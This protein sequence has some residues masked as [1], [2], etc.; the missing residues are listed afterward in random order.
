MTPPPIPVSPAQWPCDLDRLRGLMQAA[1][2]DAILAFG[3]ANFLYLTGYQNYFDAPGASVALIPADPAQPPMILIAAWMADAAAAASRITEIETFPLWLEI[4]DLEAIRAGTQAT[5]AKPSPRYDIGA[6]MR[7]IAEALRARGLERGRIGL[8]MGAVSAATFAQLATA[9]PAARLIEAAAVFT[10]LR[11]HKSPWE[12]A[13]IKEATLG[14][15]HGLRILAAT[16]LRGRDVAGLK[17]IYDAACADFAAARGTGG[18]LGTRVTAS[19]G[20]AISPTIAGGARVTGAE[21]VFF[22]CATSIHGY[23]SDTGR[24]LAFGRPSSEARQFLDAVIAG[25]AAAEPLLRPG[26][27]MCEVFHAGHEAV[28][29]HGLPWYTRGHIGHTMGLGMGEQGPYLSPVETRPLEAGMVIALETPLY[30][31]GLGGFQVEDCY[32]ITE[33]GAEKFTTL[34]RDFLFAEL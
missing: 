15:E 7:R 27:P 16:P 28:R 19:V 4:G 11:I 6:N 12:I 5:I 29:A 1:G 31:R 23:G 18:Y 34:P 30:I 22:D 17:Q 13:C 26:T 33:T 32:V 8:E 9:L 10:D 14:A 2:L 25:M 24:T 20:G 3:G 21:L